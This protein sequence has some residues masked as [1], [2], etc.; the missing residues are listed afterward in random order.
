MQ[1]GK[2]MQKN[3]YAMLCAW[4]AD[5][6]KAGH[7]H[8]VQERPAFL[9]PQGSTIVHVAVNA[10]GDDESAITVGANV[11]MGAKIT[12]ELMQWLLSHNARSL[13]GAFGINPENGTISCDHSIVGSTCDQKELFTSVS[14]VAGTADQYDDMII[15]K[16]GGK[17][18]LALATGK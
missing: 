8:Q 10:M 11:V 1:F 16:F 18:A 7:I 5:G 6:I 13:F 12:P 4:F 17:S 9:M 2:E 14:Y 3:V 15:E